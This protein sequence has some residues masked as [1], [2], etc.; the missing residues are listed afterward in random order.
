[1][2]KLERHPWLDSLIGDP[3]DA[4]DS[5]LQGCAYLPGLQRISPC[6]ALM[7]LMGDLPPEA[8]EWALLDRALLAWIEQRRDGAGDLLDRPGGVQRF[9]RETGEAF[10]S[11]WRLELPESSAWIR[12]NL[13]DLLRWADNFT[14]DPT[15]DLGRA[16]LTAGAHLQQGDELRFQWFRICEEAARTRLRHRLDNAMLGLIRLPAKA[17]GAG[18]SQ[19]VVTGLARWASRLPQDDRY[20]NEVVREWRA[21]KAAF[22]RQPGFWRNRW[23]TILEDGRY[24]HAFLQWLR[25][26]DPALSAPVGRV[27]PKREPLLPKN[28][29][30]TIDDMKKE[31]GRNGLT[32]QLWSRMTALLD[33]LENFADLTGNSYFLVTSCTSIANIVLPH[34]PGHALAQARHALLWAPSDGHAW[35]V[36]ARAL[37]QL[38]LPDLAIAVLWEGMRRAPMSPAFCNQLAVLLV[39][40]GRGREAEALLRQ[41]IPDRADDVTVYTL[42]H[43]LIGEGRFA[44]AAIALDQYRQKFGEDEHSALLER[45]IAAG[46][47]GQQSARD[48]FL[49]IGRKSEGEPVAWDAGAADSAL[50][51]ERNEADRLARIATVSDADLMFR[52]GG[53]YRDEALERVDRIIAADEFDAYAQVV[54]SLAV[55]EYR[56]AM[57]GRAGRFAASLPVQLAIAPQ[58]AASERW[59]A[60][61]R[62]FPDG[63]PL[64]DLVRMARGDGSPGVAADLIA[65]SETPSRWDEGWAKFLKRRV[66]DHL[67]GERPAN[68]DRLA[69]DAL[70]QAVDVGWSLKPAA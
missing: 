60:L 4:V 26:G 1:M 38:G 37:E 40:Q 15:F 11:A 52:I 51:A 48:H 56:E 43:L 23:E 31:V 33:Q 20:R 30:G 6:E 7:A 49:G 36:R 57:Q 16:V 67:E 8:P 35:S 46:P 9:I 10:R 28:V 24:D 53:Q 70:T 61:E 62:R 69:H 41:A 27:R 58:T 3:A 45:L 29:S 63:K 22:P 5:L 21:L 42:S 14:I 19:D 17:G 25:D 18:P 34:A 13:P 66:A 39:R 65:W 59:D 12:G 44:E 64:I 2:P 50:S 54:K 47:A 68:L 55:P 32:R